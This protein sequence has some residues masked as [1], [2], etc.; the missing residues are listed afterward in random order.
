MVTKAFLQ[1][2]QQSQWFS[3]INKKVLVEAFP[4]ELLI[5]GVFNLLFY[6]FFLFFNTTAQPAATKAT[7]TPAIAVTSPVCGEVSLEVEELEEVVSEGVEAVSYT[8]LD[9]YK[10]QK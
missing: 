1:D 7:V 10:R 3:L 2:T 6:L 5:K 9:V 8:H 4:P